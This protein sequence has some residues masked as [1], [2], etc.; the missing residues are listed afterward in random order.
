MLID[1]STH[2]VPDHPSNGTRKDYQVN[3]NKGLHGKAFR[4]TEKGLN[5]FEACCFA[6]AVFSI[7]T[8]ERRN[9]FPMQW[10]P[11]IP[12]KCPQCVVGLE[13]AHDILWATQGSQE[14]GP[15]MDG[16]VFV[17]AKD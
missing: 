5:D 9:S 16:Y 3:V 2:T 4:S 17:V 1:S 8:Q 14:R 6:F 7:E 10:A 13:C 12:S 15:S 11:I